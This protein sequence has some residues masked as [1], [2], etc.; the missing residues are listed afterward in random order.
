[1][2]VFNA[3]KT[4]GTRCRLRNSKVSLHWRHH[5]IEQLHSRYLIANLGI[6]VDIAEQRQK[7]LAAA[8]HRHALNGAETRRAPA[9]KR[10]VD[11]SGAIGPRRGG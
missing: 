6:E 3:V 7:I 2:C 11:A 10:N 8:Q 1:M 4:S 9:F 5:A